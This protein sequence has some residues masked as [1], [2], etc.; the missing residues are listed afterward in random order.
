M[1]LHRIMAHRFRSLFRRSRIEA[2]LQRELDFHIDQ[3]T[4]EQ[5]AAGMSES[6]ARLASLRQ[7]G[8]VSVVEEECRDVRRVNFVADLVRDLSYAFRLMTKSPGFTL[9]AVLTL[10]LGIGANTAMFSVIDG[11]L[12]KP[13]AYHEPDRLISIHLRYMSQKNLGITP[14]P[15]YLY[16]LWH[17]HAATLENIA[18]VRT[19]SANLTGVGEPERVFGARV[20]WTLFPTLGVGPVLGRSFS[21][22]ED[23]HQGPRVVILSNGFWRRRFGADP[24]AIGRVIQLDGASFS[25]IGVMA[26]GFELPI[27]LETEGGTSHLDVLLPGAFRPDEMQNHNCWGVARL[28]PGV[29]VKQASADLDATLL[30]TKSTDVRHAVVARLQSNMTARVQSGLSLLMAAVGLVLLIACGNLANLLLSRALTRKKEIAVR[31][32]L[33][34]S[35]G[36]ILRQLFV[37]SLVL[38]LLGGAVGVTGAG[39]ILSFILTQIPSDLPHLAAIS[40]DGRAL[41][42]CVVLTFLCALL[43]GALPAWRFSNADPQDA[44]RQSQR[45]ATDTRGS[46]GLRQW[47]IA[48]QVTLCT[49]LLIGS[50]LLI[51]SFA[52]ILSIDRGFATE[53]VLTADIPLDGERY[54]Q[55]V[56]QNTAYHAIEERL[57]GIPGVSGVGAVSWLPLSGNE[58]KNPI[59]LPGARLTPESG[60]DLPFAQIRFATPGYFRAAGIPLRSGRIFSEAVGD[61]W[62]AVVSDNAARS[63]WPDRDPIGHEF[64]IDGG[65]HPRIWRVA[66]VVA[67]VRQTDLRSPAPLMVYLPTAN[68]RGMDLSFVLRTTLPANSI[69]P[70]IREAVRQTDAYVPVIS[71]RAM[72]DIVSRS[73]AQYRFQMLLLATF[74]GIAMLLAALGIYGTLSY[75]VNQRYREIGIRLALGAKR[76][77]VGTLVMRQALAPVVLGLV[78]GDAGALLLMKTLAALLYG[79]GSGDAFTYSFSG[80][81][82]FVVAVASCWLPAMRAMR[83]NPLETIRCD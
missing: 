53:N 25:V 23:I 55:P 1:R 37:E 44:L 59:F 16:K 58:Y 38:S 19:E 31:A 12:L 33:G 48:A 71:I 63:L 82:I 39:W 49:M 34:A 30:S 28:K 47:L 24:G 56:R 61:M 65:A 21:A 81:L 3:L 50:G 8:S 40:V 2:D 57:A 75:S 72:S 13:L 32:A 11:V 46:I 29:T 74:A 43:F 70:S 6:E 77:D 83:L 60:R 17:D 73:I 45:G 64:S 51:R 15:P 41:G 10:A 42:F 79:V 80:A 69:A 22:G 20:S 5:I 67:D 62:S 18:I 35:R 66:G 78:A 54:D 52:K 4:T 9:T 14:I 36:Q 27:D 7:F 26:A 68:N 76:V